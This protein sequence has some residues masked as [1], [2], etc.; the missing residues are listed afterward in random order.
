MEPR[1][2]WG[3]AGRAV[4]LGPETKYVAGGRASLSGH[5]KQCALVSAVIPGAQY[6]LHHRREWNQSGRQPRVLGGRSRPSD[7]T[8]GDKDAEREHSPS[9]AP[10][11]RMP[12]AAVLPAGSPTCPGLPAGS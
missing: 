5:E 9:P 8:L 4:A 2:E 3:G 1:G 7:L 11:G 10:Q 12:R 6:A